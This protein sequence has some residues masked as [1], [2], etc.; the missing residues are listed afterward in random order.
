[1]GELIC[2]GPRV[3]GCAPDSLYRFDLLK[4]H[5]PAN[6]M[7]SVQLSE[8]QIQAIGNALKSARQNR[9][10]NI[11]EA[12]FRIALSPAQLRAIESGDLRPFYS[13]NYFMQAAKRYANLLGIDLPAPTTPIASI[14][15][16]AQYPA[17][18]VAAAAPDASADST[19]TPSATQHGPKGLRWGW[20]ALAAAAL[21]AL[22]IL[23]ISLDQAPKQE[24]VIASAQSVSA[25]AAGE[26][27]PA[28]SVNPSTA[29]N[30]PQSSASPAITLAPS[31]ARTSL[32]SSLNDGQLAVQTSTWVQIVKNNGDKI[33]LKTEPGQKIDFPS[34]DTAALVFGQPEKANLTIQGKLVNLGPF[35]T[36]DSPPRALVILNRI[37]E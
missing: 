31:A 19:P 1:M 33:N 13:P 7:S 12:A 28:E 32:P 4:T 8:A 34:G 14:A 21:I 3:Q 35:I 30:A 20:I 29:S 6:F 18:Q 15:L 10:D 36:Q 24:P 2:P 27:K 9:G 11:A 5:K 37:K 26:D 17:T 16:P 25:P 23:R 22:G